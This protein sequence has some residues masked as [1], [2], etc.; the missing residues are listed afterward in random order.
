MATVT[1]R[2]RMQRVHVGSG[3][4]TWTVLG[5]DHLHVPEIERFLEYLRQCDRSPNTVRSYARAMTLWW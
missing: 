4:I 1:A 3:D 5:A 2:V